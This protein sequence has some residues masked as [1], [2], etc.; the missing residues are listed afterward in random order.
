MFL[1]YICIIHR[2]LS[3]AT[4]VLVPMAFSQVRQQEMYHSG[5]DQQRRP[6]ALACCARNSDSTFS[7]IAIPG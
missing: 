1:F 6:I 4:I 2:T 7:Q 5:A 3:L